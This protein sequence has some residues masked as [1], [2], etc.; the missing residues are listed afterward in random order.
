MS[1]VTRPTFDPK[2]GVGSR[3]ERT[4]ADEAGLLEQQPHEPHAHAGALGR[5]GPPV[6]GDRVR[7][8]GARGG[9]AQ[10]ELRL[11]AADRRYRLCG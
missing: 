1:S 8:A 5:R 4:D 11:P 6:R 3:K 7:E 9:A 10:P 2:R